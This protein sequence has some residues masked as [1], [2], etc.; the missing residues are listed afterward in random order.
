M[1]VLHGI[2][3]VHRLQE[4]MQLQFV[5]SMRQIQATDGYCSCK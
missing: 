1:D 5:S 2:E 4:I 3:Q